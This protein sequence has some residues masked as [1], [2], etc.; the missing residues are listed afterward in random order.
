MTNSPIRISDTVQAA[1]AAGEPVVALESTIFTH[2]LPR[3][4]NLEVALAGEE[5]ARAHGAVPAT[6]GVFRG[7]LVVGLSP[8]EIAELSRTDGLLKASIRELAYAHVHGLSAGTTIAATAFLAH[9]AGI[10]VFATGGLGGV[11]HGAATT[12]D[13]SAD[14]IALARTSFILVSSGAKAILDIGAT[15]ERFE[16]LS[17]PV[18]G[19]RTLQ[20]PG[21]YVA[22]SGYT[23]NQRVDTP[24]QAA[25]LLLTQRALGV[26]AGINLANPVPL[27]DQ[28][29]TEGF[30]EILER[31]WA[32]AD[33][34]GISG[35]AITPYLLDYLRV[36]TDGRS[37]D[38]NVALYRNN[39]ALAAQVSRA[40]AERQR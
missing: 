7:E 25:D 31:A 33:R 28:L 14:L 19:Y 16:T 3:P 22:D 39:I 35:Q 5:V 10:D 34:D 36:A 4:R 6:I 32:D 23:L 40:L 21:F 1:L 17:V 20:Y 27:E 15:L 2:G 24:E 12:F 13:E 29:D 8:D 26:P 9:R 11:H 38:A 30:D 37:L 18:V